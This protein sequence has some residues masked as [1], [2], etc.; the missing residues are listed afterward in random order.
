MAQPAH[1]PNADLFSQHSLQTATP[2]MR[3]YLELKS[4]HRE[5]L[6]F[7]RMGDFYELFFDDAKTASDALNIALTQRGSHLDAPIPMCGVPAHS[8]ESYLQKLIACGFKV[9]ICEQMEDPAEAKKRGHKAVVMRDVVRIIT[10]GTVT[11]DTLLEA[12]G[13][14]YLAAL[15]HYKGQFALSWTDVS[16]GSFSLLPLTLPQLAAEIA[17]INPAELLVSDQSFGQPELQSLWQEYASI[18]TPQPDSCFKPEAGERHLKALYQLDVLDSL[19]ALDA[20]CLSA[21][22]ALLDYLELT[23]KGA[24]PRMERPQIRSTRHAMQMDAATR[25]NL[26][27]I[28]T[29]DG[30]KRGS[31]R[32]CI[33][34][35]ASA[36]GSRLLAEVL[37]SPL[38][39]VAA[40]HARQQAADWLK[41]HSTSREELQSR[42]KALPDMERALSRIC[43]Q[44]GTPRDLAMLR[45][46]LAQAGALKILLSF[47][48]REE[49]PPLLQELEHQLGQFAELRSKLAE[50]LVESPGMLARD[51]GF[52]REGF[53]G[54]LDSIREVR[55]HSKKLIAALQQQY[56]EQTGV[57]TL[58]IK[59]NNVLGYF[60]EVTATHKDKIRHKPEGPFIHRQSMAGAMR[61][62]TD[63][64]VELERHIIEAK[65]KALNMELALF[66]ELLADV[67]TH[68]AGIAATAQA[69]AWL[70]VL[71]SF[72]TLAVEEGYC[73]PKVDDSTAFHITQGRHPVV[74]QALRKQGEAPFVANDCRLEDAQTLWLL[75]GPNMAGKSTFLRQNALIAILAQ[76]GCFVP[77][78]AAHIGV[79]DRCF[80]RVGAADDLARGRSTFMVEMVETATILHQ[81]T[82]KSLVILDEIGRG[83]ATFDGLSIAW[84]VVE[85]LQGH[86][87][88]RGIFATHYHE[89]TALATKLA[90]VACHHLRVKEWQGNVVFLHEVASGNADRSYGIHVAKLAGLPQAVLQRAGEVLHL[91]E[92]NEGQ[93]L[94]KKLADDLP[95]FAF[96][97]TQDANTANHD[98]PYAH[99]A[100]PPVPSA[101]PTDP[102][103]EAVVRLLDSLQPDDLSPREALEALYALKHIH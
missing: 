59:H 60:I 52:I 100:T 46:G 88:C 87:R 35:T 38:L 27:L 84:A 61:F 10:P 49:I 69:M 76:I 9:A 94:A 19:G 79:V 85:H 43:L 28:T 18:L 44:R 77:A 62:S 5:M 95:L 67:L 98:N 34:R 73:L 8:H 30:H 1:A 41:N 15:G 58:K 45:D 65:D 86:N 80:S 68:A 48:N 55:D 96:T 2:A 47:Q 7:Y 51:G 12:T 103:A 64:L 31:L 56:M 90:H 32:H 70:D 25:R 99:L 66:Q 36:A 40:I 50:A 16:T 92:Q 74:A 6:L 29:L 57:N 33:D 42:L 102:R 91:L 14:H 83:T 89:L 39:D 4:R 71:A 93:T 26:E 17:R 101:P 72:A 97:D 20:A 21:A 54:A 23:Q 75:T 82:E 78:E 53:S 81:A 11:E 3:Q 63:E 22:A 37:A 24:L 13:H